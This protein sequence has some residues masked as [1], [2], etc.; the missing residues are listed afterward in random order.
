MAVT[1][2]WLLEEMDGPDRILVIAGES[3]IFSSAPLSLFPLV[4]LY[5]SSSVTLLYHPSRFQIC[6]IIRNH[7]VV[8]YQRFSSLLYNLPSFLPPTFYA[9]FFCLMSPENYALSCCLHI[10]ALLIH[11][12]FF[13]LPHLP[14]LFHDL[15]SLTS[16]LSHAVIVVFGMTLTDWYD[17]CP[18][19]CWKGARWRE[20]VLL[21]GSWSYRKALYAD[22][23]GWRLP[24]ES[25]DCLFLS[26]PFF[27]LFFAVFRS[28]HI[29]NRYF[30]SLNPF[31]F[32]PH[33]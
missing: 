2:G 12:L 14:F 6:S 8:C 15:H 16:L 18:L 31:S 32:H 9:V 27:D 21:E 17:G 11:V 20:W 4:C 22:A 23:V 10:K 13:T 24:S 19:G 5:I 25:L 28:G 26:R 1:N 30:S 3:S 33:W 29:G 7:L